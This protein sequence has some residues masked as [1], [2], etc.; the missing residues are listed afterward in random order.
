MKY[1]LDTNILV[2]LVRGSALADD[3]NQRYQLFKPDNR[4]FVSIV[5][6][7]EIYAFAYKNKWGKRKIE[8]VES[9]LAELY[10]IPIDNRE[11][12]KVYAE[13]DAFSQNK[14]DYFSMPSHISA[15][16]MGKNDLWIAATTHIL[17]ATLLT[18][19]KDFL[20]LHGVFFEVECVEI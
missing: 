19:D 6:I 10:P 4:L 13:I 8:E 18:T 11:T 3:I 17:A 5:S 2:Q 9:V 16:N 7:G 14:H 1:V 20:H 15:R 12:A